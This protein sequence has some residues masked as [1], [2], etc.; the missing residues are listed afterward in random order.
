MNPAVHRR[1][2]R[3][4]L[5]LF[6]GVV[7]WWIGYV[8]YR[9]NAVF[10]AIPAGATFVTVHRNLAGELDSLIRN[11]ATHGLLK[12]TGV[13]EEDLNGLTSNRET[14]AWVRRLAFDQTVVAYVPALGNQQKPAWVF[15]SW[16]GSQSQ[17][18]RWK[19]PWLHSSDLRPMQLD[20]GRTIWLSRARMSDPSQHLSLALAEGLLLGCVSTD[21]AGVRWLLETAD[22]SPSRPSVLTVGKLA[23]AQAL[24]PT[25]RPHWGWL[26]STLGAEETSFVPALS[27]FG[28]SIATNGLLDLSFAANQPLPGATPLATQADFATVGDLLGSTPDLVAVLPLAW[29]RPLFLRSTSPL[30]AEAL[31]QLTETHDTPP[32]ALSFLAVLNREHSGRIRGALGKSIAALVSK[33]LRVPT[34][35]VGVEVSGADEANARVNRMVDVL[36]TRY[37]LDLV[38]RPLTGDPCP[39]ALIAD[40]RRS[41]YGKFEADECIA[42]TVRDHWL[43][44]G[45]NA[46]TL[47]GL[48]N[49]LPATPGNAPQVLWRQRC[50]SQAPAYA[51]VNLHDCGRTLK[52]VLAVTQL[53][54]AVNDTQDSAGI[55]ST[56][57]SAKAWV[58]GIQSLNEAAAWMS[59]TGGVARLDLAVGPP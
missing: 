43:I 26:Q 46:A 25:N 44:F 29:A 4:L 45:S 11:P 38:V 42:Y 24:A 39:M 48:L 15:A 13:R 6:V 37:G 49:G 8:P 34:L 20:H 58:D 2:F 41:F 35:V 36:N 50:S 47:R 54:L 22:G 23:D 9:P 10:G 53:A 40:T 28:A 12:A 52:D 51:W 7:L 32:D 33:G 5:A 16:I 30:W 21:P 14:Q 1:A 19:L 56:L 18:L 55:S 27:T 3:V 17:Q 57:A 59:S 31:V